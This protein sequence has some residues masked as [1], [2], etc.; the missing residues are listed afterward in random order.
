MSLAAYVRAEMRFLGRVLREPWPWL[1][2]A[3]FLGTATLAYRM[4]VAYSLHIG[5]LPGE[6]AY[7]RPYHAGFNDETEYDASD[8][9]SRAFRWAFADARL[10]FPGAGRTSFSSRLRVVAGQPR[11]VVL[12]GWWLGGAP[13]IAVPLAP[14]ARS[15]H[16]LVPA[17]TPDLDLRLDT[18]PFQ[19]PNDPRSLA[20]AADAFSFRTLAP[21]RPAPASLAWLLGNVGLAYLLIRRWGAAPLL[22]T[23]VGCGV[24]ILFA[25]LLAW[26]RFGLTTFAPRLFVALAAVNAG[27]LLLPPVLGSLAALAC[28]TVAPGEV[29]AVT[30]LV[31]LAWLIRL[32]GLLHPQAYTSDLGLHANNLIGVT[33]GEVI[34]TEGLPSEAGGGRAPYPPA[35]YVMLL[36]GQLLAPARTVVTIGN[37]LADSLAIAS[38]WLLLRMT[39]APASA[40]LFAGGLYLFAPPL[41]KSLSVGEM[42]NVWGQAL[43]GPLLLLVLS[44]QRRTLPAWA[45]LAGFAVAFL[46]HFGVLLSLL[47]F[48]AVYEALLLVERGAWIKLAVLLLAALL[49]VVAG[50]Y[51]AHGRLLSQPGGSARLPFTFDRVWRVVAESISSVDRIGPLMAA[52]GTAGLVLVMTRLRRLRSLM[53]AW[54]LSALL[55]LGSLLWTQQT[56][57]WQAFLFPALALCGGVALAALARR[58]RVGHTL[59][60]ALL[61][62]AVVRGAIFW[63]VQIATYQH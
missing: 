35:Q 38:L 40:A 22:A 32:G 3:L 46:G 44:W 49:L 11:G 1:L 48:F 50:Y 53:L 18:P 60:Y 42:A 25:A 36:P 30:T 20:F 19:A 34:F 23:M 51:S 14:E 43:V 37:T 10:R 12:S 7:D 2:L 58:G 57:R 26:Q 56:L 15:Y 55:S 17:T 52:L 62:V 61:A 31:M 63:Y 39:S 47:L 13:L 16:L 24:V 21:A 28:V 8:R 33:R 9:P 54:W 59:A 45:L 41:L 5:K 27:S 29:R 6:L 4:P